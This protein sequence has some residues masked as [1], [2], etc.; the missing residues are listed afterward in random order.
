MQTIG[1][2]TE[3]A[4]IT[5]VIDKD[6][7]KETTTRYNAVNSR[8]RKSLMHEIEKSVAIW[9]HDQISIYSFVSD[10]VKDGVP[11]YGS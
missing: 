11:V 6:K 4:H 9:I 5:I 7:V 10:G 2:S 1:N 3:F 8:P